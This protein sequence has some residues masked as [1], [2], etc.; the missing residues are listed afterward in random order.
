VS[1][2]RSSSAAVLDGEPTDESVHVQRFSVRFDYPVHFTRHA[3]APENPS[4]LRAVTRLEPGRRH[5]LWVAVDSGFA[6][7]W[8][9]LPRALAD[10]AAAH[11]G[12]LELVAEPHL[13]PAGEAA[14]QDPTLIGALHARL[15]A[16]RMD[17]HSFVLALGG[18]A[19]L[20]T[21]GYAAATCHRGV[22]LVRMPTTVLGQ[23]DAGIGV[24]N[25]INAFG[26]KNFLGTFAPPFAVIN[27]F[28]WLSSLPARDKLAGM[29]E[30]VKVALIRDAAF[31][32]WLVAH[33]SALRSFAPAPLARLIKRAAHIH[34]Q[35][36]AQAGDPFELGSA[37]PLDYGHW[38]AHKLEKLTEHALRH[39]E[40]V[41]IG[42][43]LDSRYSHQLGWLSAQALEGIM[44]LLEGLG[45][46]LFH[47]ALTW[48]DAR[49]RSVL[50]A[51]LDEFREHMGGD[52]CVPMLEGIGATRQVSAIDDA[53]VEA[54][55]AWL[56][57]RSMARCA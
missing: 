17:R 25:G 37:R 2:D 27:D 45:F 32:D 29:A 7:H 10:Y 44:A 31:Y 3:L 15:Q 19:V 57:A 24:K 16:A 23:N 46:T 14:K 50:L 54:A 51:G 30:A 22:R 52:L 8:P 35:H 42:M 13:V 1:L 12:S 48:R 47:D 20:D 26:T 49:G 53:Q 34:L 55:I 38:A 4:L 9:N 40:A 5:R 56:A 18:G 33:T 21:V 41:A 39:G 28:A 11:A 6:Q 36:I 43:A